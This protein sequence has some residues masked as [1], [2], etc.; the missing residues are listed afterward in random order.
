MFHAS[1][2]PLTYSFN[3]T[4]SKMDSASKRYENCKRIFAL[5]DQKRLLDDEAEIYNYGR[6]KLCQ[7][8]YDSEV[9][10]KIYRKPLLWI[11]IYIAVASLFCILLMAADL[12]HGFRNRKFWFP[13]KYFTLN[14]ASITVITIAMKLPVDLS[15]PMPGF[16]DQLAKVGSMTFMCT[17]MSNLMPSLASTDNRDIFAN[18]AGM[19]ILVVTMIVNVLIQMKT[20]V[21]NKY[22][23]MWVPLP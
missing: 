14:T 9:E 13:S 11:G 15:S 17:M 10:G 8:V 5:L 6:Y 7:M 19:V 21:V 20:G 2:S 1:Y 18:V 12:F 23:A 16:I 3:Y 22:L 4:I